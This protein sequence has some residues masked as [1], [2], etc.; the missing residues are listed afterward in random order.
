MADE[1]YR[2]LNREVAER[3]LRGEPLEAVDADT[4]AR[5]DRLAEALGA[6][7]AEAAAAPSQNAELPG[8]Q[9]ALAAFRMAR[10]ARTARSVERAECLA[11]AAHSEAAEPG[12][13]SRTHAVPAPVADAGLVR[14]GRPVSSAPDGR[15]A[16]WGRPVRYGLVAALAAGMLGGVTLTAGGGALSTFHDDEPEPS[17]SIPAAETPDRLLLSPSPNA[18]PGDGER[19]SPAEP[20]PEGSPDVTP[21]GDDPSGGTDAERLP[22]DTGQ[23]EGTR[24]WWNSVLSACRDVRAGKELDA[25]RRRGLEGAAGRKNQGQLKR[26]CEGVLSGAEN[27][28]K[29]KRPGTGTGTG[30]GRGTGTG[31]SGSDGSTGSSGDDRTRSGK[32]SDEDDDSHRG[33]GRKGNG[34]GDGDGPR[35]GDGDGKG[36]KNNGGKGGKG[37]GGRG[38]HGQLGAVTPVNFGCRAGADVSDVPWTT[39]PA[40]PATRSPLSRAL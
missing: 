5:A 10:T 36:G 32:D 15:R 27:P 29:A 39:P 20:T 34:K 12:R 25:D 30:T 26:Y 11:R 14:L 17:A 9:A 3:L 40:D 4:R 8:E 7:A 1:Q 16:R 37:H 28:G 18:D 31:S 2:W 35:H 23:G 38:H 13:G 33:K 21:N 19:G 24:K 22:G 6:L